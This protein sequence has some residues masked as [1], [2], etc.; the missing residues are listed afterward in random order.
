MKDFLRNPATINRRNLLKMS[1]ILLGSTLLPACG[2]DDTEETTGGATGGATGGDM[3][4]GDM[5]G[6]DMAG[7]M[8]N[9]DA[10]CNLLPN[11]DPLNRGNGTYYQTFVDD[12][13]NILVVGCGSSGCHGTP[14][15]G[16]WMQSE[17]PCQIESNFITSQLY[18]LP[19]EVAEA[20]PIL[21]RAFDPD[22]AGY[23]IFVNGM[24]D[25][26]YIRL[27]NW[28]LSGLGID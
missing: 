1:S 15:N 18:I 12:I 28:V 25:A 24:S 23:R 7:N 17:G 21:S 14:S 11:G 2:D 20:S 22:H 9:N 6:G 8:G 26:A 10:A 16:F 3:M 4:G 27:R 19:N 13:N 5:M